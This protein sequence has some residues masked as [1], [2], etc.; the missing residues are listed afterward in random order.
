VRGLEYYEL[1]NGE[2]GLELLVN[3]TDFE[4]CSEVTE[5][6]AKTWTWDTLTG[7]TVIE[8]DENEEATE[9]LTLTGARRLI[10]LKAA[11]RFLVA[12]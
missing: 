2:Q 11:E 1:G 3:V 7:P 5:Q 8:G 4:D 6:L 10:P 12:A 9:W